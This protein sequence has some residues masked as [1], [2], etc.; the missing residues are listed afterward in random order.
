MDSFASF[1][2]NK[3]R[4]NF[5]PESKKS[6]GQRACELGISVSQ[7][8]Q[9]NGINV[10]MPFKWRR[11]LLAP[12]LDCAKPQQT[13]LPVTVVDAGSNAV[14]GCSSDVTSIAP[15]IAARQS[16][17]EI[18]IDGATVRFDECADLSKVRA[19]VRMLRA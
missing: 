16:F 18:A 5:I 12:Q 1:G 8:A 6:L 2:R 14:R 3:R 19:M 15:A 4:R 9:E 7:L 10:N 13:T 11:E 17:M